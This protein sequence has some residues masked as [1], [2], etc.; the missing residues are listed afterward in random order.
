MSKQK[1]LSVMIVFMLCSV[2]M[3]SAFYL[4]SEN[5]H[6]CSGENCPVCFQISMC[7]STVKSIGTGIAVATTVAVVVFVL[8]LNNLNSTDSFLFETPVSLKVKLTD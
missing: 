1:Y 2:L 3:F 5:N 6:E 7:E 8:I 4:V